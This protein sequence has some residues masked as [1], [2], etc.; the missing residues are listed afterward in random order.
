MTVTMIDIGDGDIS[1]EDFG[2][3]GKGEFVE[4]LCK[5]LE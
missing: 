3:R 4:E 5:L 2:L 1:L